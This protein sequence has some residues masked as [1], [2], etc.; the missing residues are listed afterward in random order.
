MTDFFLSISPVQPLVYFQRLHETRRNM[1]EYETIFLNKQNLTFSTV[2]G[3]IWFIFCFR[4]N[5]FAS[6]IW[7]PGA[8]NLDILKVKSNYKRQ[9]SY[10]YTEIN[11]EKI[12]T[13]IAFNYFWK[14]L[15]RRYLAGL[16]TS[17]GFS[18]F[19]VFE[20]VSF[21]NIPGLCICQGSEYT[22]TL[23]IPLVLN[24]SVL[25]IR[26]GFEYASFKQGSECV[27]IIF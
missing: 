9:N 1:K 17:P 14:M 27:W 4:L 6:K 19:Q 25:W 3:S 13:S 10:N 21:L 24:M 8:M 23:S 15:H 16:W 2:A 26:E 20:Y 5:I 18:T 12:Y 7:R 11:N 22:R